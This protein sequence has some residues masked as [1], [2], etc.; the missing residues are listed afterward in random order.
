MALFREEAV[1]EVGRCL[2]ISAKRTVCWPR[3]A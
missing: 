1:H 3:A 2:I